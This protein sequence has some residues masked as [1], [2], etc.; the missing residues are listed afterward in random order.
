[1]KKGFEQWQR[2][3]TQRSARLDAAIS[4]YFRRRNRTSHPE[5][6]W[7]NGG[8][9]YPSETEKCECCNSIRWPSR[10]W[11]YSLNKHARSIGHVAQL[12]KVDPRYLRQRVKEFQT[13]TGGNITTTGGNIARL[14]FAPQASDDEIDQLIKEIER[15]IK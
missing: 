8:R 6:E 11:P 5:G 13:T 3:S 9:W 15:L 2:L 14:P 1:M 10:R 7:D 12:Y 4:E